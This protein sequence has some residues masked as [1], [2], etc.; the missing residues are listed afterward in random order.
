VLEY[1]GYNGSIE[2]SIEDNCLYGKLI[3]LQNGSISYEGKTI[4]ELTTDF[5]FAVDDYLEHCA[6]KQIKPEK[7]FS[8]SFN[9]RVSPEIHKCAVLK[10]KELGTTLN[11][12]IKEII[13]NAVLN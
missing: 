8:G 13:K 10:A 6:A 11:G 2:V 7:P 1:K 12:Y 3:G 4:E 5:H 9:V